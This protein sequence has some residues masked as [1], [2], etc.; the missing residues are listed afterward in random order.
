MCC[1][2]RSSLSIT[3]SVWNAQTSAIMLLGFLNISYAWHG[4][5]AGQ[6][7]FPV[8]VFFFFFFFLGGKDIH[9]TSATITTSKKCDVHCKTNK[10]EA[11][12]T[13]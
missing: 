13:S 1:S 12:N 10:A 7:A 5:L 3:M 8:A 11:N 6:V 2:Q 9:Y 4:N